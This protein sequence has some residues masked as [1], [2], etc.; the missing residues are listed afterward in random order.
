LFLVLH[1]KGYWKPAGFLK[2]AKD[3]SKNERR[4]RT[5]IKLL[6]LIA[7]KKEGFKM[8]SIEMDF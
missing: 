7:T 3:E 1:N 2:G 8:K 4:I 6:I 5:N